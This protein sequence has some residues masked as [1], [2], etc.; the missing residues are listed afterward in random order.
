MLYHATLDTPNYRFQALGFTEQEARAAL[1]QAW[2]THAEQ[3]GAIYE[4]RDLAD[5]VNV[6]ALETGTAYRD[7][8]PIAT[9]EREQPATENTSPAESPDLT[10]T[11]EAS[12]LEALTA[13]RP[14][15]VEGWAYDD[16]HGMPAAIVRL[17]FDSEAWAMSN[18]DSTP[19]GTLLPQTIVHLTA[20]MPYG[21]QAGRVPR[22][23]EELETWLTGLRSV[24]AGV[25]VDT[26]AQILY[27]LNDD[28]LAK[29]NVVVAAE[30][31]QAQHQRA[32]DAVRAFLG[33]GEHA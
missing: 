16:P 21:A 7:G 24:L 2:N 9:L 32:A 27:S 1:E 15:H 22:T 8:S 26:Q 6:S 13:G 4:W 11:L 5:D 28:L 25:A 29:A 14:V 33:T 19:E 17:S 18:L 23:L 10:A 31:Q 20:S 3:T 30:R 12:D